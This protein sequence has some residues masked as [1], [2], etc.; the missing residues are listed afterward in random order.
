MEG[1]E[2]EG[3]EE[4]VDEGGLEGQPEEFPSPGDPERQHCLRVC[5]RGRAKAGVVVKME[6][7]PEHGIVR[8]SH[9]LQD[10]H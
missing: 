4:E 2:K 8:Q 9:C 7:W 10:E 6:V 3:R 5:N 1:G